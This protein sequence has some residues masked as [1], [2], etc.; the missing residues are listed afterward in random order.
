LADGF[1]LK[2]FPVTATTPRGRSLSA[3][4]T[5]SR[6]GYIVAIVINVVML[7]IVNNILEWGWLPFLTADFGQLIWLIDVSLLATIAVNAIYLVYDAPWFKSVCQI[8]LGG[9]TIAVAVRTYQVFPF[10]FSASQFNWEPLAR[11]VIVLAVIGTVIGM[12]VEMVKL[13]RGE[14]ASNS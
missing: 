7:V 2:G 3:H 5:A 9:I 10:D 12:I 8:G 11:F 14:P 6:F 13:A 1:E 4:P